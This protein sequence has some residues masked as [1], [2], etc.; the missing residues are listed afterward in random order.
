LAAARFSA[1]PV[2]WTKLTGFGR[3]FYNRKIGEDGVK[4]ETIEKESQREAI[5]S[6]CAFFNS[7]Y[8][9]YLRRSKT[10]YYYAIAEEMKQRGRAAAYGDNAINLV[11]STSA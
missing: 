6:G 3:Q 2:S 5:I 11:A 10:N 7:H 9:N 1:A 4:N 8:V